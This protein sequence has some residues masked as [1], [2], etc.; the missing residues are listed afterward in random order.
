MPNK[1]PC[2]PF[3]C[4]IQ[5]CLQNNR[6]QE[7]QCQKVIESMKECCRKWGDESFVCSGFKKILEEESNDNAKPRQPAT[8]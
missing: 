6:F 7:P 2:K 1:D 3:A 4:K 5:E 8:L